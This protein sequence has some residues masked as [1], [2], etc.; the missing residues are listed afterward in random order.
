MLVEELTVAER[1][2]LW[3]FRQAVRRGIAAAKL[4]VERDVYGAWEDGRAEPEADVV[5][6]ALAT[7]T[8]VRPREHFV[9]LRRRAKLTVQQVAE[10]MGCDRS[11]ITK[12]ERGNITINVLREFWGEM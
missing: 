2:F 4:G 6:P 8:Y 9:I 12:A 7:V 10:R 3:R 5:A 11:T 1:L